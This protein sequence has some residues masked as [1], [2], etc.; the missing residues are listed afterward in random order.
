MAADAKREQERNEATAV[1]AGIKPAK[2]EDEPEEVARREAIRIAKEKA[3]AEWIRQQEE[4][5]ERKE[6]AKKAVDAAGGNGGMRVVA[7]EACKPVTVSLARVNGVARPPAAPK[8]AA[9]LAT[10]PMVPEPAKSE[11]VEDCEAELE[12]EEREA[13]G[14]SVLE[15]LVASGEQGRALIEIDVPAACAR[16]LYDHSS[17][18]IEFLRQH[19]GAQI[20]V[21]R[22]A[23]RAATIVATGT[24]PVLE[25]VSGALHRLLNAPSSAEGNELG[26]GEEEYLLTFSPR[27]ARMIAATGE[28]PTVPLRYDVRQHTSIDADGFLQV[29]IVGTAAA[30]AHTQA[31]IES[32]LEDARHKP[33]DSAV[34]NDNVP[35]E[36][37]VPNA[38][39]PPKSAGKCSSS[40]AAVLAA[41]G[42]ALEPAAAPVS[43]SESSISTNGAG[44]VTLSVGRSLVGK[45]L[46]HGGCTMRDLRA[47][48][49]A[50]IDLIKDLEGNGTITISGKPANVAKAQAS[51]R[52]MLGDAALATSSNSSAASAAS[53]TAAPAPSVRAPPEA[54]EVVTVPAS[55]VG[56]LLGPRGAVIQLIRDDTRAA[57]DVDKAADGT[58]TVTITGA[59]EAVLVAKRV[60]TRIAESDLL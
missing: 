59:S 32:L 17:A 47:S 11:D 9:P 50:E 45:V 35:A 49:G 3:E 42:G 2:R 22:H 18:A 34:V 1:E 41:G 10:P 43:S 60:V 39:G 40:I 23:N 52:E 36:A 53:T 7:L 16:L 12:T 54:E 46:G 19:S 15:G 13:S 38:D 37:A 26:E 8:P 57:V 5:R 28:L 6:A 29:Y 44:I 58:A 14:L 25:V 4:E 20:S 55:R 56:K 48:S 33:R 21:H 31:F 27:D 24:P 30:T 51:I